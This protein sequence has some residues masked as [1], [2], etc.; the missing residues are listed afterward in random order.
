MYEELNENADASSVQL[1]LRQARQDIVR[2]EEELNNAETRL[3]KEQ[4][5]LRGES[6][7]KDSS[8]DIDEVAELKKEK[9]HS[10]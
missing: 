2:L 5:E 9:L 3:A 4:S 1:E 7:Y 8:V 6:Y 10:R